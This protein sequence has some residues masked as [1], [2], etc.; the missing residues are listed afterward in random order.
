MPKLFLDREGLLGLLPKVF[1]F[2]KREE[3]AVSPNGKNLL[4][5]TSKGHVILCRFPIPPASDKPAEKKP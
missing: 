2:D 5:G 1:G 4:V 3:I